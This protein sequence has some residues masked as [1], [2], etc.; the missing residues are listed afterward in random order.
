LNAWAGKLLGNPAQVRCIVERLEA[1]AGQVLQSKELRLNELGLAPLDFIYALEGAQGGQQAE[2]EQRI[3]YTIMREP[4]GFAPGSLLRINPSRKPQWAA[5]E[6]G[7]GEF[8]ELL[9]AARKLI[10]SAR[11]IDD[12][13]L[14]PPQRSTNSSVN[15]FELEQ[16]AAAGEQALRRT[17]NDLQQQLA[18][19]DTANLE[20]LRELILRSAGFGAAGAVPLS[21]AG[22]LPADRQILLAQA[23]SVQKEFAQ[24]VG[25]L[26]AL[27]TG[28]DAG[29][30]T[31][32]QRL[33]HVLARLR[34]VFGKA[35]VVLPRF[36][37]ANAD[38]LE[39]AL[40]DSEKLQDGD[41]FT[42]ITW[43]QRMARMRDGAARLHCALNY[44]EAIK[45]GEKLNLTIAQLPYETGDRWV[46]LPLQ[47][48]KSL[49]SGKLSLAVQS[50]APLD[51]RLPLAGLLIDE[52]VEVVPSATETTGLSFQYDQPNAAP[53][54]MM[55]IAVPPEIG[56][57]WTIWSLQQV[58]LETLDLARV[59]AVDPDA[60]D[61]VG[62]YLPA[63]YFASNTANHTVSTDFSTIR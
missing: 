6:L 18:A 44:A 39:K 46:G 12:D 19:F 49:P 40:A 63:L 37:P 51:V 42:S 43:F 61:E 33:D 57:P 36:T 53:P 8:S 28:F 15:V 54:Q 59:R 9:R 1:P 45:T 34:I 50:A 5:S 29:S 26:T 24:R 7:Y 10:T 62:H 30:A 58:L 38:E 31:I 41:P 4:D 25:Q 21:A 20:T 2:I 3:L 52:W 27:A 48:G 35:F 47:P 55:L 16:R 13:D 32:D 17:A 60:L 22:N 11:G 23:G 14:N 56:L